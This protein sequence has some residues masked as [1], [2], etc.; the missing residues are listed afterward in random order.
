MSSRAMSHASRPQVVV[1][2]AGFCGSG[3]IRTR[4]T[5]EVRRCWTKVAYE[6]MDFRL[7]TTLYPSCF[8]AACN[9][10]RRIGKIH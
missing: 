4:S 10:C 7:S 2:G 9:S 8:S 6:R 1:T 5:W 3:H